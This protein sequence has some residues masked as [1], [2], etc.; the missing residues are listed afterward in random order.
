MIPVFN[1]WI[2]RMHLSQQVM[3]YFDLLFM[4]GIGQFWGDVQ[5]RNFFGNLIN[6]MVANSTR[7]EV[8]PTKKP[9]PLVLYSAPAMIF[10]V[11]LM[12]NCLAIIVFFIELGF[13]MHND[14]KYKSW[15]T[16]NERNQ[17]SKSFKVNQC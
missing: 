17:L 1:I 13:M 8:L 16:I 11:F 3:L 15:K 6:K 5:M 4:S 14:A 2:V 7:S 9:L 10:C 12:S